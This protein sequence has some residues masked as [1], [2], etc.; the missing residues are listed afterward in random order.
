MYTEL[1]KMLKER[2]RSSKDLC[3]QLGVIPYDLRVLIRN[4]RRIGIDINYHRG[5]YK[6][7]KEFEDL[8][9]SRN[10]LRYVVPLTLQLTKMMR[11][12]YSKEVS[13]LWPNK[14][15]ENERILIEI[16]M[17]NGKVY[18]DPEVRFVMPA[19]KERLRLAK[20]IS[21]VASE[22]H[23]LDKFLGKEV[24]IDGKKGIYRGVNVRGHALVETNYGEV[25]IRPEEA[26]RI[27]FPISPK[28]SFQYP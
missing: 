12:V 25:T 22:W 2:D 4:L 19:I 21:N 14:V 7:V 18:V 27:L 11:L 3:N 24:R 23:I 13:P 15:I 5:Q 8:E 6:L 20:S 1:L 28:R 17:V 10:E 9:L 26:H 16:N